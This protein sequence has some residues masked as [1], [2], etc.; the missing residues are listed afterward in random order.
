LKV[1]DI[2]GKEVANLV[3]QEQSAGNYSITVDGTKLSSGIYI[4]RLIQKWKC[5][6]QENDLIKVVLSSSVVCEVL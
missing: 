5:K 6:C 1:Y 4:Y 2:L 3:N